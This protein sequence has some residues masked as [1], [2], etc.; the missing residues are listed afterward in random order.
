MIK[1]IISHFI[2]NS[3]NVVFLHLQSSVRTYICCALG[4]GPSATAA[5]AAAADYSSSDSQWSTQNTIS[6]EI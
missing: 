4:C 6:S 3:Q 1:Y 5:A 2:Y